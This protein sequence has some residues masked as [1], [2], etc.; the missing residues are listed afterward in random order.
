MT[1]LPTSRLRSASLS[2]AASALLAWVAATFPVDALAQKGA[3]AKAGEPITLN[4][5]NA[6]IDAVA[7][8]FASITG[9]N[10]VVDPRVKGTLTLV[11]DQ[12]VSRAVALSQFVSALRLQGFTLVE[13]SGLYK[14][15][16]EAEAKLQTSAVTVDDPDGRAV[17]GGN[18]IATQ[19]FKL[20]H[21]SANNLVPVLLPLISPN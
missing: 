5:Q 4:F 8:T 16:P 18:Q 17:A 3:L 15:V 12:P 13:A 7:R 19:I 11:I 21:E 20:N 6:E 1:S 2:I 10:V 14:V 9:K